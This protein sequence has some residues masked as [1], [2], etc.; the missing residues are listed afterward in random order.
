MSVKISFLLIF[1]VVLLLPP[2]NTQAATVIWTGSAS[3]DW[4]TATNWNTETVPSQSD[5][6]IIADVTN[7]PTIDLS[8]TINTLTINT[9]GLLNLNGNNL[10]VSGNLT[11]NGTLD[12]ST[13]TPTITVAG[14]WDSSTGTF[15]YKQSGVDLGST[16]VMT[17]ISKTIKTPSDSNTFGLS[18]FYNLEIN[19]EV[20]SREKFRVY[21]KLSIIKIA[22]YAT[23]PKLTMD[24]YYRIAVNWGGDIVIDGG[25]L[26]G[27]S[28]FYMMVNDESRDHVSVTNGGRITVAGFKYMVHNGRARVTAAHYEGSLFIWAEVPIPV[29]PAEGAV[30]VLGPGVKLEVDNNTFVSGAFYGDEK[31]TLDNTVYNTAMDLKQALVIGDDGVGNKRGEFRAGSAAISVNRVFI[32][33][34]STAYR[35]DIKNKL[36]AGSSTWN[37]SGTYWKNFG[38]FDKGTSTVNFTSG[39]AGNTILSGGAPFHDVIFNNVSGS[40]ILQDGMTANSLTSTM[41]GDLVFNAGSAYAITNIALNGSSG[42]QVNLS[43]TIPANS[44]NLNVTNITQPLSYVGVADSNAANQILCTNNC[45][46]NN[47]NTNWIFFAYALNYTKAGTGSGTVSSS[48]EGINSAESASAAFNGNT[49]VTLTAT[50]STGSTFAGWSG[51]ADCTD[52]SVTMIGEANCTATFTLTLADADNDGILDDIDGNGINGENPCRGGNKVNCDDNCMDVSNTDQLDFDFDG[53]GNVCDLDIDGD[54]VNNQD[55][56]FPFDPMETADSDKEIPV[57]VGSGFRYTPKISGNIIVWSEYKDGNYDIYM[58]DITTGVETRVTTDPAEQGSP[59]VSGNRIVFDDERNGNWDIYLYDI[60]T[61]TET[62]ITNNPAN[63]YQPVISGDYIVWVDTRNGNEDI[64][65]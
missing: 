21:K 3:T 62:R 18:R 41:G 13:G 8:R 65:M 2:V 28:A 60:S 22:G 46:D 30:A 54:G 39:S 7:D 56:A 34:I 5:D 61:G 4:G 42:N 14:N 12:A 51:D 43:S 23:I 38:E 53:I 37:I 10:T 45:L 44:W 9:G 27:Q 25:I 58:Y 48:P 24:S 20:A 6:V 36:V 57:I 64:Y 63:Q 32:K 1:F 49:V 35:P 50:P 31:V 11:V 15:S 52:G 55:D 19:G 17:G 16:V 59:D 26:A 40:W 33:A 29:Y 47:R